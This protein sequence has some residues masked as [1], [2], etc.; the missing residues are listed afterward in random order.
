[1][2]NLFRPVAIAVAIL[3]VTACGTISTMPP[4]PTPAD[5]QGIA[6]ELT[7][8]SIAIDHLVSGD[9]GWPDTTLIPTAIGLTADGID[10]VEPVRIYLYIF[11]DR[12][13]FERLR[14][15]VDECARSFVTDAATFETVEQ[16]PFVL[17]GQGPWAPGF[18]AAIRDALEVAAGTG[19]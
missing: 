13:A 8:R 19:N 4:A 9:G 5:F 3:A 10:Q 1:V 14:A 17:A 7:K 12:P 16:S 15:R 11:R 6:G 2:S 18:E